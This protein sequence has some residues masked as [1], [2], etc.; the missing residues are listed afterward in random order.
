MKHIDCRLLPNLHLAGNFKDGENVS[1]FALANRIKR[2]EYFGE[3][4]NKMGYSRQNIEASTETRWM[5]FSISYNLLEGQQR[6]LPMTGKK[7][8]K[9]KTLKKDKCVP[10]GKI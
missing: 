8:E 2:D 3:D 9:L 4:S 6:K 10:W 1:F 7:F 5:Y